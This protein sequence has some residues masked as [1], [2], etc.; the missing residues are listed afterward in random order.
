MMTHHV[1]WQGVN[2]TRVHDAWMDSQQSQMHPGGCKIIQLQ[3]NCTVC[4]L[5]AT[6]SNITAAAAGQCRLMA[7]AANLP[8]EGGT[9]PHPV[10]APARL[11]SG[12]AAAPAH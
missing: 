9:S 2:D 3:S 10:P 7:P 6:R 4:T 8:Q 12:A 5:L 11:N 1:T